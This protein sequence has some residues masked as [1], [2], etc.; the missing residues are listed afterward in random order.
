MPLLAIAFLGLGAHGAV[1]LTDYLI[2]DGWTYSSWLSRPGELAYLERLF[3]EAGRPLDMLFWLPFVGLSRVDLWAKWAGVATWLL[4]GCLM[5]LVLTKSR[6][7]VKPVAFSVAVLSVVLPV[8]DVIGVIALWMNT[9]CIALFWAGW[10][11]VLSLPQKPLLFWTT[12]GLSLCVFWLS[13]NLNSLL[14]FYYA[15]AACLIVLP[16]FRSG[17]AAVLTSLRRALLRFPEFAVLPILFWAWKQIFT[18]TSGYYADYNKLS[19]SADVLGRTGRSLWKGFLLGEVNGLFESAMW[20]GISMVT[21]VAIGSLLARK[22]K[23]VPCLGSVGDNAALVL[24]GFFLLLA[25]ALPYAVVDQSFDSFGWLSRNCI[26]FPLP[27]GILITGAIGLSSAAFAPQR[28][29][30][31]WLL[32]CFV[33]LLAIGSANRT[34]LRWQAFGAKQ[35][36]IAEKL[37]ASFAQDPPAVV[38]LRDYFPLPQTIY[39][40]PP[41]IW[42]HIMSYGKG[43]PRTFVV[44]TTQMA[45]DQIV[46]G[47]DG[48]QERRVTVLGIDEASLVAALEQTTMPY[49]LTG[50]PRVGSQAVAIVEPGELGVDA[51]GLGWQYLK[52]RLFDRAAIPAFLDQLTSVQVRELPAIQSTSSSGMLPSN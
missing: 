13:L 30:V 14:V 43:T 22:L 50:I 33:V 31:P 12:R 45:P 41:I 5:Y 52:R 11:L 35:V 10:W 37:R 1:L 3:K 40:Y 8:F 9:A 4:N 32:L 18:P 44:E 47:A 42:T 51:V 19:L 6:L 29:A 21:V 16:N 20:V 25:G 39:F 24:V 23:P 38:Q 36:S 28:P 49:A 27:L 48:R 2:W 26:L 34:T 7:L 17:F 15:F 46:M